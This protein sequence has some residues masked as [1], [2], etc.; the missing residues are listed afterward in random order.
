MS[1][2]RLQF[3]DGQKK[4]EI[5]GVSVINGFI[6]KENIYNS[7]RYIFGE[8]FNTFIQIVQLFCILGSQ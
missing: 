5:V 6:I 7:S 3:S 8:G 4:T 2:W 1:P